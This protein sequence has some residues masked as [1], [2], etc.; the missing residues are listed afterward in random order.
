VGIGLAHFE[1][2]MQN[3]KLVSVLLWG[4]S[5]QARS[6][7][8]S[9]SSLFLGSSSSSSS[10]SSPTRSSASSPSYDMMVSPIDGLLEWF[11][12]R[13]GYLHED[14]EIRRQNHEDS[15][16]P[17]GVFAKRG[18]PKGEIVL[19]IPSSVYFQ[20]D[21]E[22][23]S[24]TIPYSL[25]DSIEAQQA[26][27][28]LEMEAYHNDTCK[29]A[30]KLKGEL[31]LYY[32][33]PSKSTFA[34]YMRY[35]DETQPRGQIPA[36][37]SVQARQI[38]RTIQGRRPT[39]EE[40][41]GSTTTTTTQ[42]KSWYSCCSLF[43][44]IVDWIDDDFIQRGCIEEGDMD[45]HHAVALTIQRGFD[46]QL[47]PIWD[48]VNH[49][50]NRLNL[51]SNSIH[52]E[53]GFKVWTSEVIPEGEELFASHNFCFDCLE[54]GSGDN[55]GL[56]G[57]FRDFGFVEDYPQYWPFQ[58]QYVYAHIEKEEEGGDS[59]NDDDDSDNKPTYHAKFFKFP[60]YSTGETSVDDGPTMESIEF[61]E[62][63]LDRL[64]QSN[65]EIQ[66]KNLKADHETYMISRYYSSLMIAMETIVTTT[67]GVS[68]RG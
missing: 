14:V 37:Y 12:S 52:D 10:A 34:P 38:L 33:D 30:Q 27:M 15:T 13:G 67:K 26:T 66:I 56:P 59:P 46:T 44:P 19:K 68:K 21:E 8:S 41:D 29:L 57:I 5:H 35:I 2:S 18:L 63:Q 48:M 50:N 43:H 49:D 6:L 11:R 40:M 39:E 42:K 7:K 31:D 62:S 55:W 20:L 4:G 24:P 36:A 17:Y 28:A 65:I 60:G 54:D 3:R 64:R 1:L 51:D 32:R 47:I 58:D 23:R 16:S 61:F 45:A 22:E 9:L 25:S 53:E